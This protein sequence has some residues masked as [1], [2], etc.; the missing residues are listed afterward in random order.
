ML[1]VYCPTLIDYLTSHTDQGWATRAGPGLTSSFRRLIE[2]ATKPMGF[3]I[4][5]HSRHPRWENHV[6]EMKLEISESTIEIFRFVI[7][8]LVQTC[9]GCGSPFF[10]LTSSTVEA[11]VTS[12]RQYQDQLTCPQKREL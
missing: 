7:T 1:D 8:S 11:S 6:K 4:G 3:T 5:A 12:P 10:S 9:G 2:A